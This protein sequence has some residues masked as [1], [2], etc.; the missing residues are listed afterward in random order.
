MFEPNPPRATPAGDR[1]RQRGAL[2]GRQSDP[3]VLAELQSWLEQP[4]P[5]ERLIEALHVIQDRLGAL[6]AP[7]LVALAS[8]MKLAP[9]EVY[10]V[11]S[12]YHHFEVLQGCCR[13]R[14]G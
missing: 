5:R 14:R 2:K 8:W 11:A 13:R 1:V 9:A 6:P 12:F 7:H 10:E 3:A 4:P